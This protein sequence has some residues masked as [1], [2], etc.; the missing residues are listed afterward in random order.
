MNR[1]GS[2]GS[3]LV[4]ALRSPGVAA[5]LLRGTAG[6]CVNRALANGLM[7]VAQIVFA[8]WL[9]LEGFGIYALALAWL[10]VLVMIGRLGFDLATVRFVAT[11]YGANAWPLLRGF[12]RAG[13][14]TVLGASVAT[15]SALAAGAIWLK[16]ALGGSLSNSLAIAGAVLPLLALVQL[17]AAALRGLGR[18]ILGDVPFSIGHPLLLLFGFLAA[19]MWTG[20]SAS[21]ETVL[22]AYL[23]ATAVVLTWLR[24]LMSRHLTAIPGDTELQFR[25]REW[26]TTAPAMML[27]TGFGVVLNQ[28]ST[29]IVGAVSGSAAASIFGASSRIAS[30]LQIIVFS[31]IAVIGPLAAKLATRG[32]F[33]KLQRAIDVGVTTVF[34]AAVGTTIGLVVLGRWVLGLFGTD[35]VAG[36]EVLLI[37]VAGQLCAAAVAPA[38]IL[39]NMT[40][41]QNTSARILAAAAILNLAFCTALAWAYGVNGAA[42]STALSTAGLGGAMAIA[43]HRHLNLRSWVSPAGL[44]FGVLD[45]VAPGRAGLRHGTGPH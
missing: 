30:I 37:L 31:L 32:E 44:R 1:T 18:V 43:A 3:R 11:Y 8:R 36:Y 24:V 25:W 14:F 23:G 40:G 15:G 28:S 21:A 38:G 9:G 29:I 42:V 27:I 19:V 10:G 33:A 20:A 22:L 4:A 34:G 2:S 5:S 6:S 16:P 17:E 39:L 12:L 35:F 7:F 13:R 41:H 45:G 26:L